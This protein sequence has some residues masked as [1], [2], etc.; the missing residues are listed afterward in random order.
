MYFNDFW[1]AILQTASHMTVTADCA[2]FSP[3]PHKKIVQQNVPRWQHQ[4]EACSVKACMQPKRDRVQVVY[5]V[6]RAQTYTHELHSGM[7]RTASWKR[8]SVARDLA[9]R[10]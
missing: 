5:N 7:G 10:R 3:P 8:P 6:V 2:Q 1:A 9:S 4:I